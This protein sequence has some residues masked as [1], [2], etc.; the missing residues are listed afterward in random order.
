MVVSAGGSLATRLDLD[1]LGV[2]QAP[3]S[4]DG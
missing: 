1:G 4:S 3:A 2:G